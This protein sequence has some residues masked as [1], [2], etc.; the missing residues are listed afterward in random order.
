MTTAETAIVI[1]A[2]QA[3]EGPMQR[4]ECDCGELFERVRDWA[5]HIV[6][7]CPAVTAPNAEGSRHVGIRP[8]R[9]VRR[10]VN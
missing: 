6:D 7:G 9:F 3:M 4:F 2:L 8:V 1:E 5:E 10:E